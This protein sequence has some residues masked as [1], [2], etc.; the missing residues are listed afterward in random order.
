MELR[1]TDY[2][3]IFGASGVEGFFGEGYWF[4]PLL[5]PIG[6]NFKGMTFV[7]KTMTAYPN[8]GDMPLKKNYMPEEFYPRCIWV[9]PL[10][11]VAIN[12]IGL[13]NPGAE[14]LFSNGRWKKRTEPFMLS[15]MPIA[16]SFDER[17]KETERFVRIVRKHL[18][19]FLAPVALQ[20]NISCSNVGLCTEEMNEEAFEHLNILNALD[21][22]ILPKLNQ[23]ATVGMAKE[24]CEH[25]ACDGL[26]IFNA[27][28]YEE[29]HLVDLPVGFPKTSPLKEFGGGAISGKPLF[30]LTREFVWTARSEGVKKPIMA[31]GGITCKKDVRHLNEAGASAVFI[32]TVAMTRSWRVKGIINCANRIFA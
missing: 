27:L 10:R 18:P 17:I 9:A 15:Y 4:H 11:G 5:K 2:G 24:L 26:V 6:L 29:R 3:H 19:D 7:S 25:A 23:L 32:G 14:A 30:P 16:Q 31:G 1:G 21:I 8:A 28:P 12:A 20:L 22:P 13:S